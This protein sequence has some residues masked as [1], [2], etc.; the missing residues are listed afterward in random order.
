[1]GT[2]STLLQGPM[3][4][5]GYCLTCYSLNIQNCISVFLIQ[6]AM[7]GRKWTAFLRVQ[8]NMCI[9]QNEQLYI[10]VVHSI[11]NIHN[12]VLRSLLYVCQFLVGDIW[13]H[14]HRCLEA[15]FLHCMKTYNS[16][17]LPISCVLSVSIFSIQ[18]NLANDDKCCDMSANNRLGTRM[19]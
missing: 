9:Y 2:I 18:L 11:C 3:Q 7:I 5:N 15:H 1:M 19:R 14:L 4:L 17:S 8:S 10:A 12:A 6:K 16:V 13:V